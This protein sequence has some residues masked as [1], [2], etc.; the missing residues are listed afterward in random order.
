MSP[1]KGSVV[2]SA[3]PE[4]QWR[5]LPGAKAYRIQIEARVP[6]GEVI[7]RIDAQVRGT[8]FNPPRPLAER[9]AAVKLLVTADCA[10]APSVTQ[11]AAWFYI[12]MAK[13]CPAPGHLAFAGAGSSQ[14]AWSQ[15]A[16]VT[17]YEL[18][19]F[20]LPEGRL[21][22]RRRVAAT[23]SALPRAATPLLVAVRPRCGAFTGEAAY[24]VLPASP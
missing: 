22:E 18:E 17:E 2:Y 23:S 14:V 16:G 12:D 21:V 11:D 7:E 19:V 13:A 4:V 5:D 1:V 24:G 20:S 15:G 3:R 9:R 8:R 6:E 10:D